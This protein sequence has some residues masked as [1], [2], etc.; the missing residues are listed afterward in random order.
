MT[1]RVLAYDGWIFWVWRIVA[2]RATYDDGV[3]ARKHRG[4]SAR[5]DALSVGIVSAS[6]IKRTRRDVP[7]W[8]RIAMS[9]ITARCRFDDIMSQIYVWGDPSIEQ[10]DYTGR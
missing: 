1:T 6:A 4:L 8:D 5:L 7:R 2:C 9:R 10:D 3:V